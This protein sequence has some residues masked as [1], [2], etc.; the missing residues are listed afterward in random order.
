MLLTPSLV[1]SSAENSGFVRTYVSVRYEF[2]TNPNDKISVTES[3]GTD[4]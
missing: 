3:S 2:T 4:V 1:S